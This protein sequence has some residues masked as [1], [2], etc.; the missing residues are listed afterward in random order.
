MGNWGSNK[1]LPVWETHKFS[2]SYPGKCLKTFYKKQI[3]LVKELTY[4]HQQESKYAG[5]ILKK[6]NNY[7]RSI[8][9]Q[10]RVNIIQIRKSYDQDQQQFLTPRL[11]KLDTAPLNPRFYISLDFLPTSFHL[12]FKT[13]LYDRTQTH[14]TEDLYKTRK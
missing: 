5:I 1:Y 7:R 2:G 13:K 6:V 4:S 12:G 3:K 14:Q 10:H 9:I 8:K 11:E